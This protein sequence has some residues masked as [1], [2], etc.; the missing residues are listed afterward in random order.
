MAADLL[1][2]TT[3]ALLAIAVLVPI[4]L[5]KP[6]EASSSA[7]IWERMKAGA[8]LWVAVSYWLATVFLFIQLMLFTAGE[9]TG[10]EF[11]YYPVFLTGVSFFALSVS[12]TLILALSQEVWPT[13][14]ESKAS[15]IAFAAVVGY[16]YATRFVLIF[17]DFALG[18]YGGHIV[19][20][21]VGMTLFG[22]TLLGSTLGWGRNRLLM[23]GTGAVLIALASF[24]LYPGS[25]F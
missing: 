3:G 19:F 2:S 9:G 18:T 7:P 25:L 8:N 1:F 22:L 20:V 21:F 16:L 15:K 5:G 11:Y 14:M 13:T 12:L 6:S 10:L 23:L 24:V 17:R 4:F